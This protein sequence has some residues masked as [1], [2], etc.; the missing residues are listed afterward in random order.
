[1]NS[2]ED[3][4]EKGLEIR[5]VKCRWAD[6]D[7]FI[8]INLESGKIREYLCG[9]YNPKTKKCDTTKEC[10]VAEKYNSWV[11]INPFLLKR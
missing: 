2:I 8:K 6:M 10:C 5:Q 11:E 3:S 9:N 7:V 1:M 4:V